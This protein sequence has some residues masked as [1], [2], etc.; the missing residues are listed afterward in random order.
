MK[1]IVAAS[2]D[3]SDSQLVAEV[4]RLARCER[5]A[6][7]DL[8]AR[9]AELYG[10]RLHERAGFSSLFT[11]CTGA[12]HFSE[13]E[14]YDRM[15]AA[16]MVRRY[17][18]VLRL[19]SSGQIKLTT[20][21]LLAPHLT[22]PNHDELLAAA[23][24]KS[25]REVQELLA[26]RSPQP[27]VARSV[28]KLRDPRIAVA[29]PTGPVLGAAASRVEVGVGGQ[30]E[31][32]AA[33]TVASGGDGIVAGAAIRVPTPT[34]PPPPVQPLAPDR[35][36]V[37]FTATAATRAQLELAQDLLRHAI[38]NGDPAQI[39]ARALDVLVEDLVKRKFAA[40]PAP[41]ASRG[42]AEGSRHIPADVKRA[43]FVRDLGRCAFVG[44]SGRIC[45]ERGLVEFHHVSPYAAGGPATVDNIAMRCRAHNAYEAELFHGP[46]R[47]YLNTEV[48]GEAATD[49]ASRTTGFRSGTTGASGQRR[50][51]TVAP[52]GSTSPP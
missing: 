33:R 20:V 48:P 40:T 11:Y 10:R 16:K 1:M 51:P 3:L 50:S 30:P 5:E 7:A 44:A 25:K 2:T 29:V 19:L 4:D 28:R 24:G 32:R 6:T 31:D 39:F 43:V 12:L 36:H 45:G 35:Y 37:S 34:S 42:R 18:T 9:L 49:A 52:S 23:C 46:A 26:Q 17:P 47:R 22:R 14:A 21:R 15:T 8:I 13:S 27:D 38:P 41:R